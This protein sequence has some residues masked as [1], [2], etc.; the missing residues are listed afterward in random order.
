MQA[1][2][3]ISWMKPLFNIT[4]KVDPLC[5]PHEMY[6]FLSIELYLGMLRWN[7]IQITQA[8]LSELQLRCS[9]CSCCGCSG[10]FF[11]DLEENLATSEQPQ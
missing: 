8:E 2:I 9:G 1:E 6:C 7:L 4:L 5:S 3:T 10:L 11:T